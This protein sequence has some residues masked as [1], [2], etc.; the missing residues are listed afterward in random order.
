MPDSSEETWSY[1]TGKVGENRVRVYE[2]EPGSPI[3]IRWRDQDGRHFKSL[4]ALMVIPF[5]D[6]DIARKIADRVARNLADGMTGGFSLRELVNLPAPR[7]L[8]ELYE[9]LFKERADDWSDDERALRRST[10]DYW[11]ETLGPER[12][13]HTISSIEVRRAVKDLFPGHAWSLQVQRE[14]MRCLLDAFQFG[15]EQ[16]DWL[17]WSESLYDVAL[18]GDPEWDPRPELTNILEQV[19]EEIQ[20]AD[21]DHE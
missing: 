3:S 12:H 21:E 15:H 10:R 20:E 1:S 5:R 14:Y 19:V 16:K 17:H 9:A 13:L 2:R 8:A 11:L 7:T 18:P 6:K 4:S